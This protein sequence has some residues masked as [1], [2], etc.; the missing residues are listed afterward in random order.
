[1]SE[2]SVDGASARGQRAHSIPLRVKALEGMG[3][4][5]QFQADFDERKS[6]LRRDARVVQSWAIRETSRQPSIAW[7][8]WR[9][10]RATTSGRRLCWENMEVLKE[11][12]EEGNPTTLKRFH[13]LNLLGYLAI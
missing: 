12:E 11:L 7:G 5:T 3:W 1:M 6:D 13:V 8:R 9:C 4:M 10:N 2:G